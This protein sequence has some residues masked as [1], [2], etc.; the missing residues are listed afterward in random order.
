MLANHDHSEA[1]FLSVVRKIK[2]QNGV[3]RALDSPSGAW[4]DE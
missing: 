3:Y 2:Q 1:L 4:A